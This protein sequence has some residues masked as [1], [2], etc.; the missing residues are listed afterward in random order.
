MMYPFKCDFK[1]HL[2]W[3]NGLF[4]WNKLLETLNRRNRLL[5][6]VVCVILYLPV[7]GF[8]FLNN[9]KLFK[10]LR[11]FFNFLLTF[12]FIYL[13]CV[14]GGYAYTSDV[15]GAQRTIDSLHYS[16]NLAAGTFACW[17]I[18]LSPDMFLLRRTVPQMF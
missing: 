12:F 13:V 16:S 7:E 6:F 2:K 17:A 15:R 8:V 14:F 9:L 1:Y 10:P 3:I 5:V 4:D 18:S 11:H